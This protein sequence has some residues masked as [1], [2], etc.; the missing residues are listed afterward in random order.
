[1]FPLKRILN[2]SKSCSQFIYKIILTIINGAFH[3]VP[4]L[5]AVPLILVACGFTLWFNLEVIHKSNFWPTASKNYLSKCWLKFDYLIKNKDKKITTV[6]CKKKW[7]N[8]NGT[9][10]KIQPNKINSYQNMFLLNRNITCINYIISNTKCLLWFC[11]PCTLHCI[12]HNQVSI[13]LITK[14]DK[15]P[16]LK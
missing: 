12:I 15:R 9:R 16:Y 3:I 2:S 13:I 11:N 8:W 14:S 1:M 10:Q 4:D 7:E 5:F 6:P